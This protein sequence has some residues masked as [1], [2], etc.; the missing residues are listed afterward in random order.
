MLFTA[1]LMGFVGSVHCAAMCGPLA[2]AV[3]M[4][5]STRASAVASRLIFNAG[6]LLVYGLLGFLF[7]L[8]GKSVVLAGLQ[9]CLSLVAGLVMFLFL[10]LS[11]CGVDN[12]FSRS[13]LGIRHIFRSFLTERSYFAT[14]ILGGANGFLP[15]GL[16]YMAGTAS[17]ACGGVWAS[18]IYMVVFG[19]G[20]LPVMLGIAFYRGRLLQMLAR[21]RFIPVAPIAVAFVALSLILRGLSLGIPYVSPAKTKSGI[22]CPACVP[23]APSSIHSPLI[24]KK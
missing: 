24:T 20:T 21:T 11:F 3:P 5:G 22:T 8:I 19:I 13:L 9:Q 7:G 4:A 18:C 10:G 12:P 16:V 6:R 23:A 14:F 1:F 2:L 15:C 17:L